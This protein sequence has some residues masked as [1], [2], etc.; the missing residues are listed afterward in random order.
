MGKKTEASR[1]SAKHKKPLFPFA[2]GDVLRR[3]AIVFALSLWM[4]SLGV[5]VGREKAPLKFDIKKVQNELAALK[6]TETTRQES[7]FKI[8]LQELA[9]KGDLEFYEALKVTDD[10]KG[11]E[12]PETAGA[13]NADGIPHKTPAVKKSKAG[14]QSPDTRAAAKAEE[15]GLAPEA[16]SVPGAYTV[17]IAALKD[18]KTADAMVAEL[19][20]NGYAA[21]RSQ[22]DIAGKGTW[23]RVRI[24][25]YA[26]RED[27]RPVVDRLRNEKFNPMIVHR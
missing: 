19:K 9:D 1:P 2:S 26:S 7:R 4:F 11:P 15:T 27:A 18:S 25:R 3:Y 5:L 20:K 17:Q 14:T 6:E 16:D 12:L 13:G 10:S 23:F 22:G 21:Y 24:G 8:D